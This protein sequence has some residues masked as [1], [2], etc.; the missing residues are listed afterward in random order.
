MSQQLGFPQRART[1]TSIPREML[2]SLAECSD[3][4]ATIASQSCLRTM[5]VALVLTLAWVAKALRTSFTFA[6]LAWVF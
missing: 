5:A 3:A 6:T 1:A 2:Q 4:N